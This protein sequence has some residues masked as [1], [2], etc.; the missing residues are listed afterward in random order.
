MPLPAVPDDH[1]A[2]P[3]R[4]PPVPDGDPALKFPCPEAPDRDPAVGNCDPV[5]PDRD[6]AL[7][8]RC[9]P[10]PDRDPT[11]QDRR[12]PL[13]DRHPVLKNRQKPISLPASRQNLPD[14]ICNGRSKFGCQ[15]T[16]F[17][18]LGAI[19]SGGHQVVGFVALRQ[20]KPAQ[21]GRLSGGQGC[22]LHPP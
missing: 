14:F 20:N 2:A 17:F 19:E 18:P 5:T 1:P 21:S 16:S 9:P 3:G 7:K 4:D 12:P 6:P 11:P 15:F 10:V 13:P 8:L 22:A